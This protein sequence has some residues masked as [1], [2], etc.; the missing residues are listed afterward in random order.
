MRLHVLYMDNSTA[1][2]A[3][4]MAAANMDTEMVLPKRRGVLHRKQL[5]NFKLENYKGD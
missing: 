4:S 5:S 1:G 3:K 2:A